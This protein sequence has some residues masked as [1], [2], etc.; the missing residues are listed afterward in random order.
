V[1]IESEGKDVDIS[2]LEF[3]HAHK[4]GALITA[5]VTSGVILA[6]GTEDQIDAI[7]RY[8][9]NIGLAFQIADDIL[10]VIGD[11]SLLGKSVGSDKEKS[12]VT[13]PG[14]LGL[15]KSKQIQKVLVE[16]AISILDQFD[17][18]ADPLR[19]IAKYIIERKK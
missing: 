17:S 13:Y 3:I 12:K 14:V 16:D 6:G 10:N 11:P 2:V 9:R 7:L 18:K 15:E 5:S 19:G 4:T 8:G 1:D